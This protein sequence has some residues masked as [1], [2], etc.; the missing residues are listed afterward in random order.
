MELVKSLLTRCWRAGQGMTRH[1][2]PR[3]DSGLGL[4]AAWLGWLQRGEAVSGEVTAVAKRLQPLATFTSQT[5]AELAEQGFSQWEIDL[6]FGAANPQ[7]PVGPRGRAPQAH[8]RSGW[9]ASRT[10]RPSFADV[11]RGHAETAH[12]RD[13]PDGGAK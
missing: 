10:G 8:K 12:E 1:G 11:D 13:S 9:G 3:G 2:K 6:Y 4:G 5:A 7:K